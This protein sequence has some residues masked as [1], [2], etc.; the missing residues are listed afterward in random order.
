M[1]TIAPWLAP[2]D[3]L[4]AARAGAQAGLAARE[5]DIQ[6]SQSADRLQ[7]AYDTLASQEKRAA[8]ATQAR[9]QL[10]AASLALRGQQMDMLNQY[11]QQNL[12]LQQQRLSDLGD[13]RQQRLQDAGTALDLRRQGMENLEESRR[14]MM[15]LRERMLDFQKQR[16]QN[17]GGRFKSKQQADS[18]NKHIQRLSVEKGVLN[19]SIDN[20]V[21]PDEQARWRARIAAINEEISQKEAE[22][23]AL[24]DDGTPDQPAAKVAPSNPKDPLGIFK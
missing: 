13:Y 19:H 22:R 11:R 9:Q 4:G 21:D 1:A 17:V 2:L 18:I 3:F 14:N 6:Q 15:D 24:F 12:G 23:D 7:L 16:E 8:Q 10:A 20:S 5:Q